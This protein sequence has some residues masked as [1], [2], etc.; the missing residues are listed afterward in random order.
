[1]L[2][3]RISR[4]EYRAA[5]IPPAVS[6]S[7][8][9]PAASPAASRRVTPGLGAGPSS[10][11]HFRAFPPPRAR[12]LPAGRL[13]PPAGPAA[14]PAETGPWSRDGPRGR[15]GAAAQTARDVVG[16]TVANLGPAAVR[17]G[18]VLEGPPP[19][20]P[21]VSLLRLLCAAAAAAQ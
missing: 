21:G 11:A 2:S 4:A 9:P 20:Q 12:F 15:D 18:D 5:D 10:C 13:A 6:A 7:R 3:R 17:P 16:E 19:P 8:L 1:M 14:T